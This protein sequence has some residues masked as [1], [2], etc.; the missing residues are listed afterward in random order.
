MIV[1][2]A[3]NI[4]ITLMTA[5]NIS[6]VLEKL[7]KESDMN[8]TALQAPSLTWMRNTAVMLMR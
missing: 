5:T 2:L 7:V 4:D 3:Q 8:E 6:G 1:T